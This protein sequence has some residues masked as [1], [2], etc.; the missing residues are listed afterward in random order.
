MHANAQKIRL[1]SSGDPGAGFDRH[2]IL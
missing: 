1:R 2:E